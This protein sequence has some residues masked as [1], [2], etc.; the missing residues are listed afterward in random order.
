MKGYYRK[1]GNRWSFTVDI[2]KD[3]KT[4]KRKQKTLSG[5]PTKK[6]AQKAAA[7]L[8]AKIE[9]GNFIN[10]SKT[11]LRTFLI[12]FVENQ[13]K[14]NVR[15]N[16]WKRAEVI[17]NNHLVPSLGHLKLKD[18][19][20]AHIQNYF[21]E[22]LEAGLSANYI[23]IMNQ[24]LK[25]AL[26]VAV[27]W[28]L[29]EK[30]PAQVVQAPKRFKSK[31]DVWTTQEAQDFLSHMK[32]KKYYPVYLLAIYT[33]MRKGELIALRWQDISLDNET[34]QVNRTFVFTDYKPSFNEPK[35]ASS[36]RT[37]HLPTLVLQELK[38]LLVK[39]K[40][41]KLSR[42][43][44]WA[45]SDLLFTTRTGNVVMPN[46]IQKDFA[47]ACESLCLKR[48]RFH[49]LRHTHATM[50]LQMGVH[51]KVVSERLGHSSIQI[52]LDTYSHVLPS[53]QE[54]LVKDLDN[55]ISQSGQ[56]VVK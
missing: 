49:D 1:R 45:S 50:L 34:L 54:S 21:T 2:G 37:I 9:S 4:G 41:Q 51:P 22:K 20:P 13:Y 53:M 38:R 25:K 10:P 30:N 33:G 23:N 8:I 7:E 40:E 35:T 16:T 28:E 52:T 19:K 6:E 47:K 11:E 27:K 32:G 24:L 56:K 17:V 18:I 42:G 29:I 46:Q 12:D 26:D 14:P 3:S 48:I 36:I 15:S 44:L 43:E 55:L 5:F 39:A 31:F